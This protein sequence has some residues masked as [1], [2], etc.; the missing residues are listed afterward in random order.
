MKYHGME[1]SFEK[2]CEILKRA[3]IIV[4]QV[5]YFYNKD[6]KDI[7]CH[8]I[9][10]YFERMGVQYAGYPLSE[11]SKMVGGVII[12]NENGVIIGY[13]S[14]PNIIKEKQNTTKM[15]ETYHYVEHLSPGTIFQHYSAILE[16]A[17]YTP[18]EKIMEIEADIGASIFMINDDALV[19]CLTHNV[20]YNRMKMKFNISTQELKD[21]IH[22]FLVYNCNFSDYSS[23]VFIK[24]Y[25]EGYT[26]PLANAIKSALFN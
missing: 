5:A 23:D 18:E 9:Q 1:V 6:L 13:N 3:S 24:R 8:D 19:Y 20:S 12:K 25:I 26:N 22:G 11:N 21:R 10:S 17:S 15:H 2:Y 14:S 16:H 4:K 7:N